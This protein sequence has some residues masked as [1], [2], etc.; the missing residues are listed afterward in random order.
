MS[1]D[2]DKVFAHSVPGGASEQA[3]SVY[4]PREEW[5][6]RWLLKRFNVDQV[7]ADRCV[8]G[9]VENDIVLKLIYI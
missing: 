9:P 4:G 1:I 6:L 7:Q 3:R 8:Y 5:V 2:L